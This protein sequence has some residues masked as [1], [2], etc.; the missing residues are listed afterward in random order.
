MGS[1]GEIV[2]CPKLSHVSFTL[3]K[4]RVLPGR[5]LYYAG[6][7]SALH[8]APDQKL[9]SP[10][11][12]LPSLKRVAKPKQM[13]LPQNC[14]DK[15]KLFCEPGGGETPEGPIVLFPD[16]PIIHKCAN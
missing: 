14:L 15:L 6:P 1:G 8:N 11:F 9:V 4:E 2:V 7:A 16:F 3:R 13:R 10:V 5:V 12:V